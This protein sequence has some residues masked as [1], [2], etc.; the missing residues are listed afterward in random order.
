MTPVRGRGARA[1]IR[2][3][4]PAVLAALVVVAACGGSPP[5]TLGLHGGILAPCPADAA[6][7]HTGMRHPD[8]TRGFFVKGSILRHEIIG[9]MQAAVEEMPGATIVT[10]ERDY[11]HA[12][13]RGRIPGAVDDLEIHVDPAREAIVRS[14]SRGLFGSAATNVARVEELRRRLDEAGLLR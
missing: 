11:L 12:E 13:F 7:V 2:P 1:A 3:S 10:V 14:A 4:A 5:E 6:C 9:R 8:G